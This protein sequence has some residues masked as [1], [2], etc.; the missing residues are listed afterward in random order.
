MVN[1]S[2]KWLKE[3]TFIDGPTDEI[4]LSIKVFDHKLFGSS[5]SKIFI[6]DGQTMMITGANILEH[7]FKE[8]GWFDQ[9]FWLLSEDMAKEIRNRFIT[10]L[11]KEAKAFSKNPVDL[12]TDEK[13][14]PNP[15]SL[16]CRTHARIKANLALIYRKPNKLN[17]T[18]SLNGRTK[19][20]LA[21][22][23]LAKKSLKILSPALNA[24]DAVKAIQRAI[25]RG[26][27]VEIILTADMGEANQ[28][29]AIIGGGVN[30]K[31]A[32]ELKDFAAKKKGNLSIKFVSRDGV[33]PAFKANMEASHSKLMIID[34]SVII[35]G[36]SNMD[37]QSWYRSGETDVAIDLITPNMNNTIFTKNIIQRG[38]DSLFSRAVE[39]ETFKSK[40]YTPK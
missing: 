24:D 37:S 34:E 38:F 14:S 35:L 1:D 7:K 31:I 3:M 21:A 30:S 36:S 32:Y 40:Y 33:N 9:S 6:I 15:N 28:N 12:K 25:E 4:N 27:R 16:P 11:W 2:Q 22:M 13:F 23:D 5:H 39:I 29:K 19:G 18:N 26:V 10:D 8:G 20:L 17:L